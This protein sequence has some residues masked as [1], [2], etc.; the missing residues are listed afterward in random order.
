MVSSGPDNST[1]S[2]N[3]LEFM[4]LG[5]AAPNSRFNFRFVGDDPYY[6]GLSTVMILLICGAAALVIAGTVLVVIL[7][8]KEEIYQNKTMR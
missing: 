2:G 8:P 4:D 7:D 3:V 6:S 5:D 1:V